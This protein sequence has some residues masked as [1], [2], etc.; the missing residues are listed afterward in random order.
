LIV[1]PD[2]NTGKS[3]LLVANSFSTSFIISAM[4]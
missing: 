3:A 4:T 2:L 1:S